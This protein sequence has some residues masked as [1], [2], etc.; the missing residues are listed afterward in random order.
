M[1]FSTKYNW[2]ILDLEVENEVVIGAHYSC[3]ISD[4]NNSVTTE[5]WWTLKPRTPM[6]V[7]KDITEQQVAF[8]V[9]EDSTQDGVNPIKSRLAEQLEAL[10]KEKVKMPW[11]PAETFKVSL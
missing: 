1:E 11:L 5:G 10:K 9:E 8:W 7:F 3:T 2:K 4:D 6:P